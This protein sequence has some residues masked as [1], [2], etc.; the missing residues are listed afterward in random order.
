MEKP[1]QFSGKSMLGSPRFLVFHLT[2]IKVK[3]FEPIDKKLKKLNIFQTIIRLL[4]WV[5][6]GFISLLA[7]ISW[8]LT[9]DCLLNLNQYDSLLQSCKKGWK[10]A[11]NSCLL[12]NLR[13]VTFISLLIFGQ[14]LKMLRRSRKST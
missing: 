13:L 2:C 3:T 7:Q 11:G 1:T 12:T 14:K 4:S 6:D 10:P 8:L 5:D 9:T